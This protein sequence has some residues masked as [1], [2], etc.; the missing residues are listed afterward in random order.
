M[1]SIKKLAELRAKQMRTSNKSEKQLREE[2]AQQTTGPYDEVRL[3]DPYAIEKLKARQKLR[4]FY[5][6]LKSKQES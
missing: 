2:Y 1:D 4:P 5:D 3:D 6:R